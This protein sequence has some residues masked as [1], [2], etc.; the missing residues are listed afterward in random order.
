ML[1]AKDVVIKEINIVKFG[2]IES[3]VIKPTDGINVV[4]GKNESGKSTIQ[5][6]LKAMLYGLPTR[7]KS[8]EALKERDRAIPWSGGKAEGV[9]TICTGGRDIEIR[10]SFGKTSAGDRFEVCDALSGQ[11][12]DGYQADNIGE[13]LLGV[14]ESLFEKTL[15][16]RQSGV[17]MG[18][19][20]D[21]LSK[22]LLNL[23]SGGDETVSVSAAL[24]KIEAERRSIEAKDK[25]NIKGK[26]DI[27]Q[28]RLA[29]LKIER[30]DLSTQLAQTE[31]TKQQLIATKAELEKTKTDIAALEEEYNKSLDR[32]RAFATRGRLSQI[33]ECDKKLNSIYNNNDY[34]KGKDLKDE[35]VKVAAELERDVLRLESELSFFGNDEVDEDALF[36]KRQ[37]GGVTTGA[38]AVLAALGFVGTVAFGIAGL[39]PA[40]VIFLML[41][42]C[43]ICALVYGIRLTASSKN[44]IKK[45]RCEQSHT[46]DMR[47]KKDAELRAKK[48]ELEKILAGFGVPD[49]SGLS[50]LYAACAG[51]RE[52]IDSLKAAKLTFLGDETYEELRKKA[53][54]DTEGELRTVA[55][56]DELLRI[57]RGRQMELLT[58]VKSLDSKMAYEVKIKAL[59]SDVDT[60][61]AS[62]NTEISKYRRRL[63]VLAEAESAIKEAGEIW[64]SG[65]L[66]QL[67]ENLN[68]IIGILTEN[69]YTGT[70]ISDEYRV[71]VCADSDLFDAEYLSY[72][73]YEQMYLALRLSIAKLLCEGRILF[74]DDILIAYDD[75]RTNAAL[76]LF[77]ELAQE[78]QIFL[79]TCR[80]GDKDKAMQLGAHTINI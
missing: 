37:K 28:E 12:I 50:G 26:L 6:F 22:R 13:K 79:F 75:E 27:L 43:G 17:F 67:S 70:R 51:M 57:G 21:D 34:Q 49:V 25:R 52:S 80:G 10:R 8:G 78:W 19:K 55:E 14:S 59:P 45:Y 62:I 68:K 65:S 42:I 64:K 4:C 33:D 38:G 23:Q 74:L 1:P 56:L 71:R 66:P 63:L 36:A 16:I 31:S 46:A 40:M 9:L 54:A 15:W 53:D 44:M 39:L 61:I 30:Y 73:T 11:K 47:Q 20:D 29:A 24:A 2:K 7:K 69:K 72:G 32:E 41:L 48:V 76:G 3:L 18:G 58:R 77:G 35:D 5:L 60:E